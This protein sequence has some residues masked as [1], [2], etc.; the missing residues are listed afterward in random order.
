M[1]KNTWGFW[2]SIVGLPV[3]QKILCSLQ[4][5]DPTQLSGI[6]C[7]WCHHK[8]DIPIQMRK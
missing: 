3:I 4:I 5:H 2:V 7:A 8:F 6:Y 1:N